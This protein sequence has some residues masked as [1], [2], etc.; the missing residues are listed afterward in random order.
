MARG[1]GVLVI[2]V[3]CGA[4]F[5]CVTTLSG[6]RATFGTTSA[7]GSGALIAIGLQISPARVQFG[8]PHTEV[9]AQQIRD[10]G[11]GGLLV[12]VGAAFA[13]VGALASAS[14]SRTSATTPDG[15]A[16]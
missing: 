12:A 9:L 3:A 4:V 1:L 2:V 11:T 8:S 10:F 16:S 5:A 13:L 14:G 6:R 15:A 7:V